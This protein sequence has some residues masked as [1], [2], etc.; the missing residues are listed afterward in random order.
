MTV[1]IIRRELEPAHSKVLANA[2]L[3]PVLARIFTA[4]QIEDTRSLDYSLSQLLSYQA[5]TGIED[6]A[7]LL[8]K[9]LENQQRV[10]IVG[11][12]DADGATSVAVAMRG[13]AKFGFQQLDY[14]V[15]NRFEFGYGLTPEIVAVA[16]ERKPDLIITVDNGISSIEG[17][18]A[19]KQ[20]GT[21]VLVTDHHLPGAEL[22]DA[23]AIVNPNLNDDPFPSKALAPVT[24]RGPLVRVACPVA[25]T[26]MV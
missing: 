14:L 24:L 6:A 17:V 23:D 26:K 8:Q 18:V 3:H 10:L 11:D 12:F 1:T 7:G 2:N 20:L 19:A 4:R 9:A 16:A 13:L 25:P 22:P 5:L 21:K 15:P